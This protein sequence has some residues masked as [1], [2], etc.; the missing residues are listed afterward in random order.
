MMAKQKN[1]EYFGIEYYGECWS[2]M[3]PNYTYDAHGE[4]DNCHVIKKDECAFEACKEQRQD[5]RLCVGGKWALYIYSVKM[6]SK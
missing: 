3:N 6:P 2:G 1:Y 4:S 5:S